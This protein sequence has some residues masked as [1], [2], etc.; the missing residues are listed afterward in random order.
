MG[1]KSFF[2]AKH[3]LGLNVGT[4]D[5]T[6]MAFETKRHK[7]RV[8][9]YATVKLDPIKAKNSIENAD[10]YLEDQLKNLL[11]QKTAN[12]LDANYVFVSIPTVN[13]FSRTIQLP[14]KIKS[15]LNNAIDLEVE[16]YIPVP[17]NMLT[18]SH[19]IIS[20]NDE[21][22]NV[23]LTAAPNGI[24][25]RVIQVCRSANIEPVL[26][27]PS[28]NSLARL[29]INTEKG[30]LTTLIIDI[31]V[32]YT[33]I[34]IL[35]K[36]VKVSSSIEI[37]GSDFT[38]AL[39]DKLNISLDKAKQLKILSGF[40]KGPQQD[41]ITNAL[42]PLVGRILNEVNKIV[43]YNKERLDGQDIDQILIV[44][45]GSNILGLSDFLTNELQLPVRIAN[46]WSDFNFGKLDK[47]SRSTISRFLTTAGMAWLNLGEVIKND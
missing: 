41:D 1:M 46:P 28:M 30:D 40:S 37:G 22:I 21:T 34:A 20:H 8:V 3:L 43:R 7:P 45:N 2:K 19:E 18:V 38:Q 33:D 36:V 12:K 14:D 39:S 42:R 25:E 10:G 24:I 31:E 5:L 23:S 26:I 44:G 17:R 27:E 47:P 16:Q 13:T 6:L 4:N 35:E 11:S 9:G 32:D 15:D 29:L